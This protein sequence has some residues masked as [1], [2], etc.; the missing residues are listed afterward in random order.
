MH[1]EV[2]SMHFFGGGSFFFFFFFFFYQQTITLL[3][4]AGIALYVSVSAESGYYY[5][6]STLTRLMMDTFYLCKASGKGHEREGRQV[7]QRVL[8][9][10][11]R[12]QENHEKKKS[13]RSEF[14]IRMIPS[15]VAAGRCQSSL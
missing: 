4:R 6:R 5:L 7:E 8:Q 9:C 1:K 11:N 10:I 15:L 2:A 13:S 3:F 12:V 14:M